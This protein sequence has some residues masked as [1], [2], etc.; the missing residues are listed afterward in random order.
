MAQFRLSMDIVK[1]GAGRSVVAVAA[2]RAGD[3]LADERYGLTHD[4][5]RRNGMEHSEIVLPDNAPEWADD[6]GELWNR[7]EAVEK[8]S[9]AHLAREVQINLPHELD[10]EAR[11]DLALEFAQHVADEYGF[12][13]D[14]AIHAPSE[15]GDDRNHHAHVLFSTRG[16]DENRESG[17]VKAKDRRFDKIAM[18]RAGKDNIVEVL[19]E[20]WE[21]MENDAL[22]RYD[23]RDES[24]ELV[25]V[26]RL[27]YERQGLDIEPT[28]HEGPDATAIKRSGGHSRIAEQNEQ[29]RD[30]N[31]EREGQRVEIDT[32]TGEILSEIEGV[33]RTPAE[34][35]LK[36][37]LLDSDPVQALWE[38]FEDV[39]RSYSSMGRGGIAPRQHREGETNK[40]DEFNKWLAEE[41][42]ERRADERSGKRDGG[43][44]SELLDTAP[45][46]TLED[47]ELILQYKPGQSF[48]L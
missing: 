18:E 17:W 47:D 48:T 5:T 22:R 39:Q 35:E 29:T 31:A 15:R 34:D 45:I 23:I 16:F 11:R 6:R 9:A 43:R 42:E 40:L 3:R 46:R 13:V 10:P 14:I 27:S 7:L 41:D 38:D 1:R 37:R 30:R 44:Q 21:G 12:A 2:Y 4:Y 28:Q 26:S 8:D 19:R 32:A 25:Q 20:I 36:Y 33:H 24:G